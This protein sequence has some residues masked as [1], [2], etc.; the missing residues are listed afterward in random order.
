LDTVDG[1]P[2]FADVLALV[3]GK[4]P[5][6]VEIKEDP[7]VSAVSETACKMLAEYKGDFIVES[8]N[9]LSLRTVRKG[10]PGVARGILSHR[11][12]EY[13]PYRKP[14]YFLLQSLLLNFLCRPAFIAY[15][16][17]HARS[18]ALR[19]VRAFF[20]VPTLAWTVRSTEEERV[21]RENGFDS[22]IFENYLP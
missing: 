9:P 8:F 14:L 19:F 15:D 12:Y 10:L 7:G 4:V 17:K 11:Y 22:I 21:A 18:F 1:I 6:L 3:N 2:R 20:K 16:H 13:E 5:L